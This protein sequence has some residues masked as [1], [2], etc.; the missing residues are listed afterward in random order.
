MGQDILSIRGDYLLFEGKKCD[1]VEPPTAML[2]GCPLKNEKG[3]QRMSFLGGSFISSTA[4]LSC[5]SDCP[6]HLFIFCRVSAGQRQQHSPPLLHLPLVR[7][8][9]RSVWWGH[10][11]RLLLPPLGRGPVCGRAPPTPRLLLLQLGCKRDPAL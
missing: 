2:R 1:T 10:K 8:G 3:V 11:V 5:M 4:T 7:S 9:L 6:N